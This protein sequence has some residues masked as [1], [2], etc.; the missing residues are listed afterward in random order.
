MNNAQI[1][2]NIIIAIA[3]FFGG[4]VLKMI[5]DDIKS[6]DGKIGDLQKTD[7]KLFERVGD[8]ETHIAGK[9]MPRDEITSMFG[10]VFSKLDKII[11]K[12]DGKADK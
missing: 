12:L 1:L 2:F 3:A 10:A 11:D 7:Q 8:I 5:Y 9:Y 4:W 6:C